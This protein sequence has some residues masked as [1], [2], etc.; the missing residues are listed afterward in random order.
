M[1]N[2]YMARLRRAAQWMLLPEDAT[3]VIADYADMAADRSDEELLHNMGDPVQAVRQ[4]SDGKAYR[5]WLCVFAA[6]TFCLLLIPVTLWVD[7]PHYYYF[8]RF[9]DNFDQRALFWAC[10]LLLALWYRWKSRKRPAMPAPK[11]LLLLSLT[12]LLTVTAMQW[13]QHHLLTAMIAYEDVFA[14][15]GEYRVQRVCWNVLIFLCAVIGLYALV[16]MRTENRR[17]L[18]LFVVA[19]TVE[20]VVMACVHFTMRLNIEPDNILYYLDTL[21]RECAIAASI[22][23]VVAGVCLC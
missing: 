23:I 12:A 3:E 11:S 4:L 7:F 22:G 14:L 19:L 18:A 15:W 6:L 5:R 8:L 9:T 20:L 16:K 17:W 2:G 10:G 1:D 21:E 13:W